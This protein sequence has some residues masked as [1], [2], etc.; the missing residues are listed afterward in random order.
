MK[1]KSAGMNSKKIVWAILVVNILILCA[2]CGETVDGMGKDAH[3][4]GKGMKTVFVADE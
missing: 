1:V 3:R 4:I 2:G